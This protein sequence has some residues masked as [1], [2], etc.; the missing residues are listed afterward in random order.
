MLG[1]GGMVFVV[2]GLTAFI[3]LVPLMRQMKS[4]EEASTAGLAS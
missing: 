4:Q 2:A 1:I 3:V